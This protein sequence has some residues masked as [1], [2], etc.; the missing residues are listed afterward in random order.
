[1]PHYTLLGTILLKLFI[2]KFKN[3]VRCQCLDALPGF[4]LNHG[5]LIN[6]DI[7]YIIFVLDEIALK[8]P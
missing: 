6:E 1:M 8:L 2:N 7:K 3:V 4:L 5:L